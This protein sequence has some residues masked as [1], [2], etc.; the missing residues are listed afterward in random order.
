MGAGAARQRGRCRESEDG[1][2][3]EGGGRAIA[4]A[5][6]EKRR[7]EIEELRRQRKWK[8]HEDVEREQREAE[9]A[10]RRSQQ[11]VLGKLKDFVAGK[12]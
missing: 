2:G 6:H 8:T 5:A 1:R 11:G 12:G 3:A 7:L 10:Q 4:R 9:E